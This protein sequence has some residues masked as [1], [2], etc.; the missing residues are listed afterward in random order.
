MSAHQVVRIPAI[1]GLW[2][3]SMRFLWLVIFVVFCKPSYSQDNFDYTSGQT[4]IA[5]IKKI[6]NEVGQSLQNVPGILVMH[7][8][9]GQSLLYITLTNSTADT[10]RLVLLRQNLYVA[11]YVAGGIFYRFNDREFAYITVP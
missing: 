9:T 6:R 3:C 2:R 1:N 8:G 4:Y 10:I 7:A 5:S 11:G